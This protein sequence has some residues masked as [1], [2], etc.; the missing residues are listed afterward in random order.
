M[1]LKVDVLTISLASL[2]DFGEI[3]VAA[4]LVGSL[5]VVADVGTHPKLPALVLI[6]E[7]PHM[8]HITVLSLQKQI[9]APT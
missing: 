4:A 7:T 2:I 5:S 3:L 1:S 8:V 9:L 6:C